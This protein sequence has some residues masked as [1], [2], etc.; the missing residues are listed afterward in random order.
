VTAPRQF[1]KPCGVPGCPN[2]VTVKRP[3]ELKRKQYCSPACVYQGKVAAGWVPH[4]YL[5]AE[6]RR[7]GSLKGSR[8]ANDRSHRRA[9]EKAVAAVADLIPTSFDHEVSAR[10]L[11]L[12][13]ALLGRAVL[14]GYSLGVRKTDTERRRA[15]QAHERT[16]GEAA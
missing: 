6:S 11:A 2:L 15:R 9:M 4:R 14:R 8:V 10:T 3:Y 13:K 5:T 12:F 1:S 16:Q 7:R